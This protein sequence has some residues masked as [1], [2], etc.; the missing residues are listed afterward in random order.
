MKTQDY[1][2]HQFLLKHG[3]V[4]RFKRALAIYK[5]S[6]YQEELEWGEF[7]RSA[8]A[9]A[10]T[11]SLTPEGGQYWARLDDLYRKSFES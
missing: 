1:K 4:R 8:I 10:F 11:W 3:A 9:G 5:D 7:D 2:L 6:T